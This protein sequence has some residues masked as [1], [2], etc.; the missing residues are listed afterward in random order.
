MIAPPTPQQ[1]YSQALAAMARIPQPAYVSFETDVTGRGMGM[2]APC[3]NGKILWGF[4]WGPD[5]R[6][7]RSWHATYDSAN[8]S[9]VIRTANGET[10][11]G[12]AETFD[13][14]TWR[15]ADAWLQ[16]GIMSPTPS[17]PPQTSST[18]A[19]GSALK[20]IASVSVIAPGAYRITDGGSQRCPSGSP[21]HELHFVPRFDA[22]KHP[23]RDAVVEMQPM[24]ICMIRFDLGSYQAVGSG[25]RGDMEL[26]FGD[27]AGNW[28]IT[29]GRAAFALRMAGM[30]LKT[31]VLNFRYAGVS[32][33]SGQSPSI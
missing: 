18:P 28:I 11:R 32:F 5:M 23:L 26:D 27:V 22:M 9:E 21:G 14:P 7:Q 33:P 15:D 19:A 4:G 12:P 16:H 8:A 3:L 31:A 29:G 24:R 2:E 30:S 13:R 20:T 1:Y 25:Y 10:C 6:R 17:A